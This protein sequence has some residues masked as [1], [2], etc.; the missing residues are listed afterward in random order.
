MRNQIFSIFI[1]AIVI[2]FAG[3][4]SQAQLTY[5]RAKGYHEKMAYAHAAELYERFITEE[6]DTVTG[7]LAR[8]AKFGLVDCQIKLGNFIEAEKWYHD[9][10]RHGEVDP[11]HNYLMGEVLMRN[12]KYKDA[13][14]Y[15]KAYKKEEP[16]D[17]RTDMKIWS[18]QNV[19]VMKKNRF[20]VKV[21]EFEYNSDGT[22]FAPSFHGNQLLFSSSRS[23]ELGIKHHDSHHGENFLD[24]YYW[25]KGFFPKKYDPYIN[26]KFHEGGV[27]FDGE[28][29]T[30]IFAR[31]N[32]IKFMPHKGSDKNNHIM[33]YIAHKVD[34][35]WKEAKAFPFGSNEY[36]MGDPF[37]SPDRSMLFFASDMNGGFGG[38]DLYVSHWSEA[39]GGWTAPVNLGEKINTPGDERSPFMLEDGTFYF[40]SDGREGLGGLDIYSAKVETKQH[41]T[42]G[43]DYSEDNWGVFG[44]T[45]LDSKET[46]F[47]KIRNVGYPINTQYDDFYFIINPKTRGGYFTSN[48]PEGTGGDDIY[49]FQYLKKKKDKDD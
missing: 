25:E 36:S 40:A 48:R 42:E 41:S 29:T 43:I 18:C 34:G 33:I 16:E 19:N 32:Y 4:Q 26:S 21:D 31:N 38:A 8:Q 3:N 27:T 44:F 12:G 7:G 45:P 30:I 23:T 20:K 17:M 37:L 5:K 2:L 10:I 24:L 35:E 47:S 1:L 14:P 11:I 28:D 9:I 22:D 49:Q 15:F 6:G 39:D 46:E 13:I